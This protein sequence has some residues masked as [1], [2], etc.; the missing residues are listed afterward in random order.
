MLIPLAPLMLSIR[1]ALPLLRAKLSILAACLTPTG[2]VQAVPRPK[3]TEL[4]KQSS[5][6]EGFKQVLWHVG[7]YILFAVAFAGFSAMQVAPAAA[8]AMV[9]MAAVM[10]CNFMPLHECVHRSAFKSRFWND[11]FMHVAG[12]LTMRP[13]MHYF[14]YHWA[15]HKFTGDPSKDSELIPSALD[16]DVSTWSGY[17]LYISGLPFWFD[18]ITTTLKHAAGI[19]PEHY[20]TADRAKHEVTTEARVYTSFYL[21]LL[22]ASLLSP[23]FAAGLWT[24]AVLPSVLGQPFLRFYLMAEHRGC[25][26]STN[27][28]ENTR[29]MQTN[30]LIRKMTWQMPYHLEHHAW[31][32][33]PFHKLAE[34][35]K[36]VT[37]SGGW[38]SDTCAPSGDD[39]YV[40]LNKQVFSSLILKPTV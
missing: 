22:A 11:V 36:L 33:V 39:G 32:Y 20:L 31:P 5:D 2:D 12:V 30:W 35:N 28:L 9:G 1:F 37:A 21:S 16:M 34:A 26:E 17:L 29:T 10:A 13:A 19:C 14:Y 18:A 40:E 4:I 25:R 27:V 24:Y 38:S 23:A 6:T 15:H 7:S 3:I 8:L